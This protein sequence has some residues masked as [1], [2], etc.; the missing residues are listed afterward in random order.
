MKTPAKKYL[1]I[2]IQAEDLKK[3]KKAAKKRGITV[4][5]WV[6]EAYEHKLKK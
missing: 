3:L 5:D 6:R 4:S 2:R 1:H